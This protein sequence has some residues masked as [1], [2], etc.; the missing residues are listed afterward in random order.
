MR[1]ALCWRAQGQE[2][3]VSRSVSVHGVRAVDLSREPARYRGE[4]AGA[5]SQALSS[6]DSRQRGAQHACQ[7]QCDARLAYLREFRRAVDWYRARLV[8]RRALRRGSGRDGL[9]SR[10]DDHRSVPVGVSVGA[11]S[12]DQSR[13]QT[14]HAARSARQYSQLYSHLRRQDAR[15]QCARLAA[16]RSQ[17]PTT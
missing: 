1:G 7:R 14:A 9:C 17:V 3:L 16:A 13:R 2:L 6:G 4:P 5:I 8:C 12:F 11:I 15:C 10:C